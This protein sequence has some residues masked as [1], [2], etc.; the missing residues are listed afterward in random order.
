[1]IKIKVIWLKKDSGG[2]SRHHLWQNVRLDYFVSDLDSIH[3]K[4]LNPYTPNHKEV[5]DASGT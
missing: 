5:E 1:M 3:S 2:Y 4:K